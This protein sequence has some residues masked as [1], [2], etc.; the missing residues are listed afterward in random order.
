MKER[1]DTEAVDHPSHVRDI[2]RVRKQ[3]VESM[4]RVNRIVAILY[5]ARHLSLG[6]QERINSKPT[7][8]D[9]ANKLLVALSKKPLEAYQC[10]L[11]ALISTNQP[12][13]ADLLTHTGDVQMQQIFPQGCEVMHRHICVA[14]LA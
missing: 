14:L 11:D 6:E 5:Q 2:Q 3:L 9:T 1:G 10:F 8:F 13:L 4:R 7:I 12:H